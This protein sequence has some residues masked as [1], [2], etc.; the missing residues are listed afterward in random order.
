MRCIIPFVLLLLL[1]ACSVNYYH[2]PPQLNDGIQ[3]GELSAVGLDSSQMDVLLDKANSGQYQQLH[4]LL[5][6]KDGLLVVE[7]YFA[8]NNDVIQFENNVTRDSSAPPIQWSRDKKHYVASVNKALTST[9]AGITLDKLNIPVDTKMSALLPPQYQDFF[10]VVNGN[11]NA[12]QLTVKDV[13]SMQTG[14]VWDEW[15]GDSLVKLWQSKNF[16]AHLLNQ[17]NNGPGKDFKYNSAGPNMLLRALDHQLK[18]HHKP[19]L[20]S[21]A[22]QQFYA[23]LGI[24][25]YDWQSQPDGYPEGSARMLMRPRDMLKV[26][27]TYLNGGQWQGEQVIPADW[28]KAVSTVQSSS[29]AGDYSYLFWL[30]TLKG[31]ERGKEQGK[32]IRYLSADGDG[33]QYINIVPSENMVIVMTQGNY[34]EWPVYSKQ[35]QEIMGLVLR[36][37]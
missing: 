28:V 19:S 3:T 16:T 27:I 22:D 6:Y 5:I 21:W 10:A 12:T 26:G 14:F 33:G 36:G 9:V 29:D 31:K 35:A 20:R 1:S 2:P 34:F 23:K 17:P 8:G 11:E 13:L 15:A 18:L 25:D 37:L 7:Q 24:T 30:R 4:S 32:E